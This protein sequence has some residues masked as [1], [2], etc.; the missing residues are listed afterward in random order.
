MISLNRDYYLSTYTQ[1]DSAALV[2]YLQERQIYEQ[3]LN[4]PYPYTEAHAEWW[5][6][7]NLQ[8]AEKQNGVAVN[9]AIRRSSDHKLIGDAGFHGFNVGKSESAELGY[10]LAKPYWNKGIMTQAAQ[11]VTEIG[12]KKFGL[13]RITAHIFHYN[14]GSAKV[15]E[16]CGY[17]FESTLKDHYK[18]DGRL[19]DGQV[20]AKLFSD[21]N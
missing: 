18:K 1:T 20:Y 10:W 19:Y 5:I 14:I 8:N 16:K 9:W 12:F 7:L 17:R 21:K 6:N 13:K 4:I 3:T 2:E 11:V 15:L